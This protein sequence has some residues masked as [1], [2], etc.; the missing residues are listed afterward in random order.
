VQQTLFKKVDRQ[1]PQRCEAHVILD[2][3]SA[4]MAPE[5]TN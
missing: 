4:H 3:L 2:N 5:V 1:V